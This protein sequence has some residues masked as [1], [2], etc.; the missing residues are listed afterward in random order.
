[1]FGIFGA[2]NPG[3]FHVYETSSLDPGAREERSKTAPEVQMVSGVG[4]TRF[5]DN[6]RKVFCGICINCSDLYYLAHYV[7]SSPSRYPTTM[8]RHISNR[9][10][11]PSYL[12][13]PKNG[14]AHCRGG[15][16]N[17]NSPLLKRSDESSLLRTT[18]S[19][20]SGA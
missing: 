5:P 13:H 6:P 8:P 14:E 15:I 12:Q 2:P 19:T 9:P 7:T 17:H 20:N 10:V 1:M 3:G 18:K 16:S 4:Q 11:K